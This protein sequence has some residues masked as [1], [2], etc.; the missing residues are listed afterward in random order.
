M[1][2]IGYYRYKVAPAIDTN[3][4]F[5]INAVKVCTKTLVVRDYCEGMKLIKFLN[6]EGQFR[7]FNFN[8]YWESSDKPKQIGSVN[9]IITS[10]L[11]SQ[12]S[13]DNIGYKNKRTISVVADNVT[14]EELTILSDLWTSPRVFLYIGDTTSYD[15]SDWLQVT[16]KS[17]DGLNRI[18]KGGAIDLAATIELPGWYAIN[19]L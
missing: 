3:V 8:E 19:M 17:K 6:S 12:S 10:L 11:T 5:Y 4:D 2:S 18:R 15:D 9:K 1:S 14:Q 13:L 16:I 7:F